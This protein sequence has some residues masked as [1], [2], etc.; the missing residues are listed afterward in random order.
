MVRSIE[1]S[2]SLGTGNSLVIGVDTGSRLAVSN[3][4][5]IGNG[6][7]VAVMANAIASV[8]VNQGGV[9]LG[10]SGG[11]QGSNGSELKIKM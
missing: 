6:G 7:G 5:S 1:D 9:S 11:N 2:R 3:G 8:G 4:G 10:R